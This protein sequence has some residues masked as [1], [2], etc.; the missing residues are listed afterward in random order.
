MDSGR[1]EAGFKQEEGFTKDSRRIQAGFT[2]D[3]CRIYIGFRQD[4]QDPMQAEFKQD[5]VRTQER[6][7]DSGRIR[8][9]FK[10]DSGRIHIGP[11]Q[12]SHR[13]QAGFT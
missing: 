11:R 1:I 6:W 10:Y 9:G 8:V 12:D 3:S 2:Q 7:E 5:S 4:S 13:I